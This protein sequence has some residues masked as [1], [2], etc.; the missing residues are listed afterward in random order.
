MFHTENPQIFG[1]TVQ[2][3]VA[4]VTWCLGFG[5]P[6]PTRLYGVI[7]NCLKKEAVVYVRDGTYIT[8]VIRKTVRFDDSHT[9]VDEK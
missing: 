6:R 3:L 8:K 2:N 4:K 7:K 1:A 9:K 5:H